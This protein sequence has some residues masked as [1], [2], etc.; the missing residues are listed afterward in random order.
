MDRAGVGLP[1]ICN[2]LLLVREGLESLIKSVLELAG[3][4]PGTFFT[5]EQSL[6]TGP[7]LFFERFI[8]KT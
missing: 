8:C 4:E 6:L 1:Q 3:L 7:L 2:G 5:V